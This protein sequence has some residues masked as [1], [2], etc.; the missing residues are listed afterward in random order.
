VLPEGAQALLTVLEDRLLLE[1][2]LPI[3]KGAPLVPE[4]HGEHARALPQALAAAGAR[5]PLLAAWRA[6]PFGPLAA[7]LEPL[8]VEPPSPEVAHHLALLHARFAE[9]TAE[10]ERA[11]SHLER[12]L[13]LWLRLWGEGSYLAALGAKIAGDGAP[14]ILA[15][16]PVALLEPLAAALRLGRRE[17]TPAARRAMAVLRA[18]GGL[19]ARAGLPDERRADVAA[20][21]AGLRGAVVREVLDEARIM[22]EQID[23]LRAPH[24]ERAAPFHLVLT[25]TSWAGFDPETLVFLLD[26]AQDQAWELYRA[27]RMPDVRALLAPLRPAID[28]LEARIAK[29][30]GLLAYRALSAQMFTFLGETE[31]DLR[32][33]IA[34]LERAVAVC[35]THR[36]ARLILA[37]FLLE[38][39]TRKLAGLPTIGLFGAGE[40]RRRGLDE[41][42][43]LRDRALELWPEAKVPTPLSNALPS[44][45]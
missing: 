37:G 34:L 19:A 15:G 42:R 43:R 20:L 21:A 18:A 38:D 32:A 3:L 11:L 36:N 39:A 5:A 45:P 12:S 26:Q 35:P 41:L 33:A 10:H 29:D 30:T 7:L 28:E 24:E 1:A 44:E 2:M 9:T 27:H 31:G 25:F 6:G 8:S 4:D 16:L 40:V 23:P 13:V 14:A 22:A 17:P